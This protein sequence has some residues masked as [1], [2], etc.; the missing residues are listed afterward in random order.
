MSPTSRVSG[1]VGPEGCQGASYAV[2]VDFD[3][4]TS[5]DGCLFATYLG[6]LPK[7]AD[8]PRMVPELLK[9]LCDNARCCWIH[10][11]RRRGV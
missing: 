2:E 11:D 10:D 8:R 1:A 4:T 5:I 6:N 3:L 9:I 7:N